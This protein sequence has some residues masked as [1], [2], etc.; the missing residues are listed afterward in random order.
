ME[1]G[2]FP[3]G[4]TALH[5]AVLKNDYD[6]VRTLL[7]SREYGVDVRS[8]TGATPLMMASLFGRT[9]I[10][11][12][13]MKKRADF[14]KFDDQNL[15][16]LQYAKG[17]VTSD[18]IR[19]YQDVDVGEPR[20]KGRRSI[21]NFLKTVEQASRSISQPQRA[22]GAPSPDTQLPREQSS[23]APAPETIFLRS[24]D[25]SLQLIGVQRLASTNVDIDL[26]RKSVGVIRGKNEPEGIYTFAV[27]GWSGVKGDN[28]LCNKEYSGLVRRVC[29]IYNFELTATWFDCVSS[30][31][32]H[33]LL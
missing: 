2:T 5:V 16:A 9:R 29:S 32:Q 13:L 30:P 11:F 31:L 27:S 1:E 28:V 18:L 10:F 4:L 21:Y 6:K 7:H 20:K 26:G 22:L 14:R 12:Y 19:R 23:E 25:G 3:E 8:S 33:I 15:A 24:H 17:P